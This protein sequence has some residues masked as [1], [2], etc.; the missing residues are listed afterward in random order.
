MYNK[1]INIV[2][3]SGTGGTELVA[4]CFENSLKQEG[5]N[6]NT[7]R[8]IANKE[9]NYIENAPLLLLFA[10]HAFNAPEPVYKWIDSIERVNDISAIVISVSGGGEVIP[11]TAC[12]VSS[13]KGL[14]KKG[15][16]VIYENMIVMPSNWIVATKRPLAQMLLEVLPKKVDAIVNDIGE[17]SLRRTKPF[18]IDRFFSCIGEIEKYGARAF[19]K[20]IKVSETCIRCG[21][22]VKNCPAGNIILNNGKPEFANKCQ[23]CLCCI[24]GCPSKA[25][26][27]GIGKFVVIREGYNLKDFEDLQPLNE[28]VDVEKIAKGYL[29]S[30]VRKYLLD[31]D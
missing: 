2:Y 6:V 18:L 21:W 20:K 16:K 24:Y 14:E 30:G 22:C 8:L 19:G 9:I 1:T 25:L 28:H 31:R 5:F 17:E 27:P 10:V 3:Y 26:K 23:L 29:W 15:Y 11:N 13:I 4:K 12:R 7:Q